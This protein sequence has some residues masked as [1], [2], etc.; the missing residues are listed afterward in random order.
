M[1]RKPREAEMREAEATVNEMAERGIPE[2]GK[3]SEPHKDFRK[4]VGLSGD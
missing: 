2:G 4:W 1:E 3:L